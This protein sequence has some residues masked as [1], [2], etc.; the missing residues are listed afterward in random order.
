M[1]ILV[2]RVSV[3]YCQGLTKPTADGGRAVSPEPY[4][5]A[6][7]NY[8]RSGCHGQHPRP[9]SLQSIWSAHTTLYLKRPGSLGDEDA[10]GSCFVLI[11]THQH[12]RHTGHQ[13]ELERSSNYSVLYSRGDGTSICSMTY[14]WQKY[15]RLLL[16]AIFCS[17]EQYLPMLWFV[18][19][20]Y[21]AVQGGSN[22]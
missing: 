4:A 9:Q 5:C 7:P 18:R 11:R 15:V 3:P 2:P 10:M 8:P 14:F 12:G 6:Q 22:F 17:S 20:C 16:L 21:A 1:G 19:V 13:E